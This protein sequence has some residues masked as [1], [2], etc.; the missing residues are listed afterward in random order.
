MLR[1]ETRLSSAL[2]RATL[3]KSRRRSSDSSGKTTR[4]M[5]PSLD[6][7]TPRSLLRMARSIA[8]SED[9]SKGWITIIR[10]SGMWNEASWFTGVCV[11]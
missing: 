9:L 10:G 1:I 7:F 11:P 6:G 8:P 2:C 4:M 3:M 5:A